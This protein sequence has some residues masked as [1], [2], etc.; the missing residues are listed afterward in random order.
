M[1]NSHSYPDLQQLTDPSIQDYE[2]FPDPHSLSDPVI[3]QRTSQIQQQLSLG[4]FATKPPWYPSSM[5]LSEPS[6]CLGSASSQPGMAIKPRPIMSD[7]PSP[8]SGHSISPRLE[9]VRDNNYSWWNMGCYMSPPPSC[10]DTML[11]STDY[12]PPASPSTQVNAEYSVAPSQIVQG[13]PAPMPITELELELEPETGSEPLCESDCY[14]HQDSDSSVI[15]NA[16][17]Y[18]PSEIDNAQESIVTLTQNKPSTHTPR[19][20]RGPRSKNGVRK[21]TTK[22]QTTAALPTR[23]RLP[24]RANSSKAKPPKRHRPQ[25]TFICSFA[26]YGC[27]SS[28]ASKN[29]WK[30]HEISQ[31]VQLGFY[32]CDVGQCNINNLSNGRASSSTNDF[33]RKDLFVQHQRRMHSPWPKYNSASDD[34]KRQFNSTLEHVHNRCWHEQRQAPPRSRC[35]FCGLDFSG[36]DSWNKRMEHVGRHFEKSDVPLDAEDEDIALRDWAVDEGILCWADG[37]WKLVSLCE[38]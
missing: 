11:P 24:A 17:G 29:E 13:Y 32:R 28:F 9:T 35:G 33:N 5:S 19:R 3:H 2:L 36:P 23:T 21:P 34:Q 14:S 1:E 7:I 37:K 12:W 38:K 18:A 26:R 25:R 8:L 6:L 10:A 15:N 4:E 22:N 20:K 31:H 16:S 30:R 27:T